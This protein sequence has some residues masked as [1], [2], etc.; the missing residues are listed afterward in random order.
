LLVAERGELW[1]LTDFIAATGGRLTGKPAQGISGISIDSRTI[2]P[3]EAFFAIRGEARDGHS[4]AAGALDKGAAL[5]V[6][7]EDKVAEIAAA[8]LL[9]VADPLQALENLGRAARLRSRAQIIAVTGSVGKTG[10]KEMLRAALS[11]SGETHASAASYNNQWGVPLSLAL[12]PRTARFAIFE[13]GMNH[14]GEI[15]PLARMI[16]PHIAI[17]TAVAPVHLEYFVSL[18]DIAAAKAEIFAGLEPGGAAILNRDNAYFDFL[19]ERAR[20]AGAGRVIGFGEDE[21]ADARAAKL[22]LHADCSAV[23]ADFHG[24]RVTYKVGAPG[25]HQVIN[26]LAVL[27]AAQLAG[28]DLA[29]GAMALGVWRAPRGRGRRLVFTTQLGSVSIID[30]SYNANPASMRAAIATLGQVQPGGNGRRIAVLGDMLELGQAAPHLHTELAEALVD[31]N[32]DLVYTAGPMMALLRDALP[33]ALRA[34]HARTADG[35]ADMLE[36]DIRPGDVVMIKGSLGSR[37]APLVAALE[38]HLVLRYEATA[39]TAN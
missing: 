22:S 27:A 35:L 10:T 2:A 13:V 37:M 31:A 29:R 6:V 25:K 3:G 7:A 23:S 39:A 20:A 38:R 19:A 8:P 4:F 34:G 5:A 15:A 1:S 17:V 24:I 36:R 14:P 21:R 33:A 18:D 12:L 26:S 28:G 11:P 32:V 30:E 9:V 16:R